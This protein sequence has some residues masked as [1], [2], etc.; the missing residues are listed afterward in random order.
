MDWAAVG[1][2]GEVLGALGVIASVIYLAVQI[3]QN[4]NQLRR[5]EINST[6]DQANAIRQRQLDKAT[7]E[8]LAKV[9]DCPDSELSTE[10]RVRLNAYYSMEMWQ[11]FNIWD[12]VRKGILE[13][14]SYAF[15]SV[16]RSFLAHPSGERWWR[17]N[18][19]FFEPEFVE[20]VEAIA[21]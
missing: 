2:V 3:R 6:L 17:D 5:A 12:R 14:Q 9:V 16:V 11:H 20:A 21:R 8:L 10:E 7:A 18:Q 19:Q 1:A 13:K 15:E 4:T